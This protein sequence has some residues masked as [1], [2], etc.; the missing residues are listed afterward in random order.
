M[1]VFIIRDT[2]TIQLASSLL[3]IRLSLPAGDLRGKDHLCLGLDSTLRY[4]LRDLSV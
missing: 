1:R 2:N 4:S 3:A